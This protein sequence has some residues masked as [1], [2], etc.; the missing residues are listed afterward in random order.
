[1]FTGDFFFNG[2]TVVI[3]HGLGLITFYCHLSEINTKEKDEL[4]TGE[5]I[6]LIGKT[7]RAPGAY[8]HWRVNLNNTR[9]DPILLKP[10]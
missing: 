9:I 2:K 6:G 7:G 10:N 4:K 5:Q 1:M 3:D 8:L